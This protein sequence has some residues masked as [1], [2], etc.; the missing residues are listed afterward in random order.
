MQMREFGIAV[1]I[2]AAIFLVS[3]VANTTTGSNQSPTA[4]AVATA[5]G[6][7]YQLKISGLYED[8]KTITFNE[9]RT[10]QM[11]W[12]VAPSKCSL[13]LDKDG[14]FKM[15][16]RNKKDCSD[17]LASTVRMG[18][19]VYRL[20]AGMKCDNTFDRSKAQLVYDES[21]WLDL[22]GRAWN[23]FD[24]SIPQPANPP[25]YAAKSG[26]YCVIGGAAQYSSLGDYDVDAGWEK[27]LNDKSKSILARIPIT[28]NNAAY[29]T[30]KDNTGA[31][32]GKTVA[33]KRSGSLGEKCK[34]T[35]TDLKLKGKNDACIA[36][37]SGKCKFDNWK[38]TFGDSSYCC[39]A[40]G[41][42]GVGVSK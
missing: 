21:S 25:N 3:V 32:C 18:V 24:Y 29:A 37:N 19:A 13:D 35:P 12:G 2:V 39:K 20:P 10:L 8:E 28:I 17:A 22:S 1:A 14:Y 27:T 40:S 16:N 36:Q 34:E 4:A 42:W 31:V 6:N 11:I 38:C 9:E 5:T 41:G 26:D 15:G 23:G 7:G 33:C 30:S